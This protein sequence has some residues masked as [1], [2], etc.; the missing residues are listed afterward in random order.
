[1]AAR[2]RF[3][4]IKLSAKMA[5]P[6]IMPVLALILI[7]IM[8]VIYYS[9]LSDEL[10]EKL[11][12]EAHQSANVLTNADRD[13]YQAL[14][15]QMEMEKAKSP[16]E[17]KKAKDAY[18]ENIQQVKDRVQQ[19]R[20]IMLKRKT[21]F[22]GYKHK[23]SKLTAFQLF[24][25]FDKDFNTFTGLF[26]PNTNVVKDEA[27]FTATFDSA[28]GSINQIEEILDAYSKDIIN[29]SNASVL[30]MQQMTVIWGIL[31]IVVSILLG[32]LISININR[33]TKIALN[34]IQKT[35]DFDL[36]YDNSYERHLDN[37]D[38]FGSIIK[39]EARVRNEL[40]TIIN[41][42]VDETSKL[43]EA[44]KV[45]NTSMTYLESSIEDISA[46]TEQIS[47]GMEETAA[48][49]EEMNATSIEIERSAENIAQRAQEGARAAEKIS[50]RA[51]EM[52][53][54]I[55]GAY[56]NSV[57]VF[58]DVTR[59]LD[60]ALDK[61][62][63]V[64]QIKVLADMILQITSQTNLLALNAAIEAA[65]A[66]EAGMGFAV[67]ADEIRK[68]AED[69]K[70]A[71]GE[72]QTVTKIVTDSVENLAANSNDLLKF[73][74]QDVTRDYETMLKASEQY[75]NDAVNI[76]DIV[77]DLSATSEELLASIQ[78]IVNATNEVALS[79]NE[80]AAGTANIA[81]KSIVIAN[82]AKEVNSSINST[83]DGADQLEQ[84]VSKFAI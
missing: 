38:E 56:E 7:S 45:T 3:N 54:S 80:G 70:K 37:K 79:A 16:D 59:K 68:L 78:N 31:A 74:S 33:R 20:E 83:S 51:D 55:R 67:V 28:R 9:K 69:S 19:A 30:S 39:A 57:G 34:L 50:A 26:D 1:M 11:Y 63:A 60:E 23:D 81:E 53:V 48:S 29:Q 35:A 25:S 12:N 84:M 61:S 41:G 82:K 32:T 58:N 47:A 17:L 44:I 5:L 24:D 27:Q 75:N 13:F 65:R 21:T 43:N 6:L 40:R 10:I 22:E 15:A 77:I 18:A 42:I 4:N 8:S 14:T 76:N 73:V 62:K 52:Q 64:E 66:G 72:I 71:A 49:T 46:T 36:K 2:F